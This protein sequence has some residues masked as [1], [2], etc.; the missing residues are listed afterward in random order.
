M[1]FFID[2]RHYHSW[3]WFRIF[4]HLIN[5]DLLYVIILNRVF[6]WKSVFHSVRP[7]KRCKY[8]ALY[9]HQERIPGW[10]PYMG[11]IINNLIPAFFCENLL[12]FYGK[13]K[14]GLCFS[15]TKT[16]MPFYLFWLSIWHLNC[17]IPN[18]FLR[19]SRSRL[20]FFGSCFFTNEQSNETMTTMTKKN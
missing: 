16:K 4:F 2:L 10:K 15:Q 19:K 5:K 6:V 7:Y 20:S 3:F 1:T 17:Y 14:N 8:S 12:S 11:S 9:F 18:Y 13:L